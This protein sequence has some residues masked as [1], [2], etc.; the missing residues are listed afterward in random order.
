MLP[1]LR[2]NAINKC[3]KQIQVFLL[4]TAT[5]AP[6]TATTTTTTT[7][8]TTIVLYYR[9][10]YLPIL[11]RRMVAS[12]LSRRNRVSSHSNIVTIT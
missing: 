5:N 4:P 12:R 10:H 3:D 1:F 2:D 8:T 7:T 6:T 11:I 9:H